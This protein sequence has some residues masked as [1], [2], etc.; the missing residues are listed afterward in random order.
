MKKKTPRNR[1]EKKRPKHFQETHDCIGCPISDAQMSLICSGNVY[2]SIICILN[3]E[4][5]FDMKRKKHIL[6]KVRIN[7]KKRDD[8][9]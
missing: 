9:V 4:G 3:I 8:D 5:F 2:E 7:Q 6:L 1:F